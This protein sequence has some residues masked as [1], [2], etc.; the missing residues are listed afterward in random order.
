M[1]WPRFSGQGKWSLLEVGG[2][3]DV[4]GLSPHCPEVWCR[5]SMSVIDWKLPDPDDKALIC[6]GGFKKG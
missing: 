1:A 4:W 5:V 6:G 3:G 2:E